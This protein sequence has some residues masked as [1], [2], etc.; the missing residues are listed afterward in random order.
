MAT[1]QLVQGQT[2]K[3]V[4]Q[5]QNA[6]SGEYQEMLVTELQPR[7]YEQSYRGNLFSLTFPAASLAVIST[8]QA[9]AFFLF[10]PATSGKNLAIIDY[11][12]TV[13][14]TT[15]IAATTDPGCGVVIGGIA[16]GSTPTGLSASLTPSATLIG[17]GVRSVAIGYTTATLAAN[18]SFPYAARQVQGISLNSTNGVS[19]PVKDAID[20]V[21]MVPP[22]SGI[23][24]Y[25]IGNSTLANFT[26][27]PTLTWLELPV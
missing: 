24:L 7:Y 3:Q 9:G 2:G 23:N 16:N 8:A 11:V 1:L 17:S 21:V 12:A 13:A 22:N 27:Q 14:V 4:G 26:I 25:A 20:G 6:A 5:G 10:N 18:T 15:T 19:A